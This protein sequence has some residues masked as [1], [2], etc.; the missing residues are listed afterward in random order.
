[1]DYKDFDYLREM[2]KQM[3]TG[4]YLPTARMEGD[5]LI[6]EGDRDDLNGR[7]RVSGTKRLRVVK[8]EEK[9]VVR[10]T[11][12]REDPPPDRLTTTCTKCGQEFTRSKFNPYFT[13]C[14][15][16]RR[17]ERR[18]PGGGDRKFTCLKCGQDFWISK[19]QPYLEPTKCPRCNRNEGIRR[20][21]KRREER[22]KSQQ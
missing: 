3:R 11:A 17:A 5:I 10:E 6:V 4:L 8:L 16:C 1:M 20:R 12:V 22:R 21:Q 14:P 7:Y 9:V 2:V 19:Y 13:E 18:K 15:E